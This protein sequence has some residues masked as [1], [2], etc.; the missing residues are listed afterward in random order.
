MV[1]RGLIIA[2]H[3]RKEIVEASLYLVPSLGN[4]AEETDGVSQGER[5]ARVWPI[6]IR[7]NLLD[8]YRPYP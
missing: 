1:C 3:R 5:G 4:S 8:I 6:N 2:Y 7:E